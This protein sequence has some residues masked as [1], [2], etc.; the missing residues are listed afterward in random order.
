MVRGGWFAIMSQHD[1]IAH[2]LAVQEI[3]KEGKTGAWAWVWVRV[4]VTELKYVAL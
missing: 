2:L 1:H 3:Q 4:R